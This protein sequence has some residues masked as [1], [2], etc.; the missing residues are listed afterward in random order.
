[1]SREYLQLPL[2]ST[3]N[4]QIVQSISTALSALISLEQCRLQRAS[5]VAKTDG[6][7]TE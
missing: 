1:M 5:K 6:R 3:H 4:E 7:S 2:I